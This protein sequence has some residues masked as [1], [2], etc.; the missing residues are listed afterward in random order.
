MLA[1]SFFT[2]GLGSFT[3]A[4]GRFDSFDAKGVYPLTR[5]R[6]GDNITD[7]KAQTGIRI[8]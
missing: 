6:I 7:R 8:R 1:H 4:K 5:H 2:D 3:S